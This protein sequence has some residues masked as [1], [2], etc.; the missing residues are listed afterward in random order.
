MDY[1]EQNPIIAT[2]SGKSISEC[3]N[4]C[5]V[6]DP[7]V[8]GVLEFIAPDCV[9]RFIG[10]WG[11]GKESEDFTLSALRYLIESPLDCP[12]R[13]SF[14]NGEISWEDY[15][16][17]KG[18]LIELVKPN[19]LADFAYVRYV[20]P[21]QMSDKAKEYLARH[22]DKCPISLKHKAICILATWEYRS[23]TKHGPMQKKLES[24]EK[25]YGQFIQRKTA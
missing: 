6:D 2:W 7:F 20:H 19:I 8:G 11:G 4:A 18:W 13:K 12:M 3:A 23:G 21:S 9:T 1:R 17:H 5:P 15:W 22:N 25:V 16:H 24:F 10:I 14:V